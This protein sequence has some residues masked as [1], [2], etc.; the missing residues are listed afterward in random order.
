MAVSG[1]AVPFI[2]GELLRQWFSLVKRGLERPFRE[3]VDTPVERRRA[4][5]R[6]DGGVQAASWAP[7]TW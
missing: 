6:I 3:S 4:E 5:P 7:Y 2:A 1:A